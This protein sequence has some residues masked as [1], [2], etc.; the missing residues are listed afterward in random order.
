MAIFIQS[1]PY[2]FPF[3]SELL[4]LL[5]LLLLKMSGKAAFIYNFL[6]KQL[7]EVAK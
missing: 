2:P 4:K 5:W 6:F 7:G 3:L 1:S